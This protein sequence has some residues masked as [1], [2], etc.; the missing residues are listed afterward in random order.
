MPEVLGSGRSGVWAGIQNQTGGS[1]AAGLG[2]AGGGVGRIGIER[3]RM[4]AA[5]RLRLW[6]FLYF[7]FR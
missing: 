5:Y 1:Y 3:L 6:A 4:Y 2:A 7:C